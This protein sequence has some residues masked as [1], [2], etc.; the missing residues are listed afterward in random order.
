MTSGSAKQPSPHRSRFKVGQSGNP[1]GRPLGTKKSA[2]ASAFDIVVDRTL[3]IRKGGTAQEVSV[4]EAL[5]HQTYRKAIEGDIASRRAILKMIEKR[6]A[7]FEKH[8]QEKENRSIEIRSEPVDPD[9]A[10]A[11]MLLLGIATV[12]KSRE[13]FSGHQ[14]AILLENWA[15]QAALSRRRGGSKLTKKEIASIQRC[16]FDGGSIKWPRGTKV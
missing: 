9:N 7:Y 11:A 13:G 12:D 8:N 5:Q 4:E 3:T 14:P 16:T 10:N 15:V 2:S 6:E 1:K